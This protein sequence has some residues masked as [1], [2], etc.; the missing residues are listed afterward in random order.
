MSDDRLLRDHPHRFFPDDSPL[1]KRGIP[2]EDLL[3]EGIDQ[4]EGTACIDKEDEQICRNSQYDKERQ[5][6]FDLMSLE[7]YLSE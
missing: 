7:I 1:R 3:N 2:S 5:E 6:Q 4:R